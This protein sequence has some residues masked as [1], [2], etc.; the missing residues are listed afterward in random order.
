MWN[1]LEVA[2]IGIGSFFAAMV[3][4]SIADQIVLTS[5]YALC[6]PYAVRWIKIIGCR[7]LE[8]VGNKGTFYYPKIDLLAR[9]AFLEDT[10][11]LEHAKKYEAERIMFLRKNRNIQ[12]GENPPGRKFQVRINYKL[13][14]AGADENEFKI[15]E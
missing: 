15:N 3:A 5:L 9:A 11:N 13:D 14:F 10:N 12:L 4:I 8:K 7:V 2:G 6:A 1:S